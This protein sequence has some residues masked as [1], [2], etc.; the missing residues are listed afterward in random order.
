MQRRYEIVCLTCGL[1]ESDTTEDG[2]FD[3]ASANR[4]AGYHEGVHVGPDNVED[5]SCRVEVAEETNEYLCPGCNQKFTGEEER[6]D[7]ATTEP[8]IKQD[9]FVRV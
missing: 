6:D 3:K 9:A 1:I 5:H 4:R 7:H 8:G 2:L